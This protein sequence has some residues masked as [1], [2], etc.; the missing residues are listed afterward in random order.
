MEDD[1]ICLKSSVDKITENF[2]IANYTVSSYCASLKFGTA[3]KSG[4][5]NIK[6]ENCQ[7]F[8]SR[9]PTEGIMFTGLPDH[10]IEDVVMENIHLSY[11]GFRDLDV[12]DRIVPKDE[13]RYPE[14]LFFGTLPS[15]GMYLRHVKGLTV[16]NVS[17]ELR[18]HDNRPAI[19]M[20]DVTESS[21]EKLHFDI[22]PSAGSS[23][24]ITNGKKLKFD[25]LFSSREVEYLMKVKG[26]DSQNIKL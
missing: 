22:Q 20:D 3:S 4:F 23:I 18:D 10:Y 1:A 17:M 13:A 14:Q 19:V 16:K 9:P 11:T 25:Q 15:Y 6:V 5:R 21:F 26:A 8:D 12:K 2:Y 7:I 24:L